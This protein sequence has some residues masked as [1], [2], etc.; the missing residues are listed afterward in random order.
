MGE[1]GTCGESLR[2]V[3]ILIDCCGR[4]VTGGGHSVVRSESERAE[5]RVNLSFRRGSGR[6][7]CPSSLRRSIEL[8]DS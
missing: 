1:G 5:V 8:D 3:G 7:H 2:S 4:A 6:Y